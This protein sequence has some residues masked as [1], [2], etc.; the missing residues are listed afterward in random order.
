M[1]IPIK[2]NDQL[3]IFE[4]KLISAQTI[5]ERTKI[6]DE[7]IYFIQGE[8]SVVEVDFSDFLILKDN[9]LFRSG[10]NIA[11]KL[12]SKPEPIT[13]CLNGKTGE[14]YQLHLSKITGRGLKKS[15]PEFP[16]GRLF[17]S[18]DNETDIEISDD[19]SLILREDLSFF[20]IP[21]GDAKNIGDPIDL[22]ECSKHN[23]RPPRKHH[24]KIKIDR[25]KYVV[26]EAIITGGQILA[27]VSK[28]PSEWALNQK[29]LGGR[30]ARV[31]I[32]ENVDLTKCGVERFETVRRQA[33]QGDTDT[34][35]ITPEDMEYLNANHPDWKKCSEGHG[36]YGLI[37]EN[38]FVPSGYNQT[39]TNLML[40]IPP[41]YPASPLDMFYLYP[42][43]SKVNGIAPFNLESERH[44]DK[45]WQRWSR[46]YEW[47]VGKDSLVS[48]IEFVITKLKEEGLQ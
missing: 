14:D 20:V 37:I 19:L 16:H 46:H 41:S 45:N 15:D 39:S 5:Y 22:E 23:R 8:A 2:V 32:N 11:D 29:F 35:D 17:V 38:F 3:L 10:S 34:F 13:I 47:K 21:S 1:Q 31:M 6:V 25:E 36:K 12:P 43:L 44:F 18:I 40:L 48:H 30:R 26:S 4:E 33:Q 42:P 27:I 9:D 28:D 7:K 24:Y